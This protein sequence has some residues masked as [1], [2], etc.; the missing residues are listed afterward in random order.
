MPRTR[1]G[2]STHEELFCVDKVTG[3]DSREY[4][5]EGISLL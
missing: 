1:K 5:T 4:K 3:E 2:A